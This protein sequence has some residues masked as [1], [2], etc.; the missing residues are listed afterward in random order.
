MWK[1][2]FWEKNFA[3]AIKIKDKAQFGRNSVITVHTL[4]TCKFV[5][6]G[7]HHCTLERQIIRSWHAKSISKFGKRRWI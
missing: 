4:Y 5:L 7:K 6:Y 1:G 2:Y 3:V